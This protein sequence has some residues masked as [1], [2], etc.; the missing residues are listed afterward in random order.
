MGWGEGAPFHPHQFSIL[1]HSPCHRPRALVA[2]CSEPEDSRSEETHKD[3]NTEGKPRNVGTQ[4]RLWLRGQRRADQHPPPHAQAAP[5]PRRPL[6]STYTHTHTHT[7]TE[8][9]VPADTRSSTHKPADLTL[10]PEP[11]TWASTSAP[12]AEQ[13]PAQGRA[14]GGGGGRSPGESGQAAT[15]PGGERGGHPRQS[16]DC[17]VEG[18]SGHPLPHTRPSGHLALLPQPLHPSDS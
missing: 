13:P 15:N 11:L 10:S 4:C 7:P 14:A 2:G 12:R 5:A 18:I 1:L 16:G 3:T 9:H 8:T 6:E 17:R